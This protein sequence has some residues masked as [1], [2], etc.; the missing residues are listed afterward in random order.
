M[1]IVLELHYCCECGLY[2]LFLVCFQIEELNK[3]D[4]LT[5]PREKLHCLKS[6][7][8]SCSV[9]LLHLLMMMFA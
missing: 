9:L 5:T 1:F 7:I 4:Q 2:E 8:V 3:M 6:V